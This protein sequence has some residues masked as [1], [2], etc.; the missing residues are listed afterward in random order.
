MISPRTAG[1]M[2]AAGPWLPQSAVLESVTP[3]TPGV[4]TY[5]LRL[6]SGDCLAKYSFD[7]GQFN[8]LYVPGYGEAAISLSG[9]TRRAAQGGADT[10]LLVH[11]IREVGSVTGA[12]A[13]MTVGQKL[14]L[15][16]PFGKP[17]PLAE[18]TGVDVVLVAGGIGLAPLRPV[19]YEILSQRDRF[20]R[21]V[22]LVGARSPEN[23]LY[24]PEYSA[25]R[26]AG[27]EIHTTVDRPAAFWKGN[28]GVVPLLIDR[29][30]LRDAGRTAFLMCGPEVMMRFSAAGALA[31][32]IGRERI[33]LSL[34][35]HMQCA[36]GLCGHCQLGTEL[37]CRDGPVFRFDRVEPLLQIHDL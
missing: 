22:L 8:M 4:A 34:E 19:I 23:L 25:W 32:G 13:R 28:V 5:C 1:A 2:P 20:G 16:G 3:E 11:T 33:W 24:A 6:T 17:W 14:A 29:L 9:P 26:S 37:L 12:I 30:R 18:L 27:V 10:E 7:P 35:R 36:V 31:R 15:R 21:C